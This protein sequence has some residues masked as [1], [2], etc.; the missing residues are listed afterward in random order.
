MKKSAEQNANRVSL[1]R[2]LQV[3]IF[4]LGSESDS[5][6]TEEYSYLLNALYPNICIRRINFDKVNFPRTGKTLFSYKDDR[7]RQSSLVST[8]ICIMK[9]F[10][11]LLFLVV[12]ISAVTVEGCKTSNIH[13][14]TT[15]ECCRGLRCW[16]RCI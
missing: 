7:L 3:I 9:Y 16:R 15:S 2:R 13:C 12:L 1:I 11:V 10:S 6:V 5:K 14:R 4:Y 8:T